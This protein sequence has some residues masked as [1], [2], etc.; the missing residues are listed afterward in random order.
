MTSIELRALDAGAIQTRVNEWRE[1]EFRHICLKKVGQLDN[2]N[3]IRETRRDIARALTILREKAHA[4]S[5][6]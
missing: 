1:L 4:A 6:S 2:T 3:V 5:Q